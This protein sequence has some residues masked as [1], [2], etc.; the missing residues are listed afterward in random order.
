VRTLVLF[1][2]VSA[3]LAAQRP[4]GDPA[5]LIGTWRGT[6]TCTDRVALPACNDE[7][8]VYEFTIG[9]KPGIIL[10]K[11]DKVVDGQRQPMGE[12]ELTYDKSES[13]WKVETG[14]RVKSVWR[15]TV[16]GT[17]LTGTAK[18]LPGNEMVRK[19]DLRK[20]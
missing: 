18:L 7:V 4:A 11:A 13:S 9:A 14:T 16:E 20:Q 17:H 15:L 8:A 10:W 2:L 3:E 5:N 12:L 19:I 1:L 6:S